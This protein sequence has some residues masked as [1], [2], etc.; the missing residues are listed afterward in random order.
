MSQP[1]RRLRPRSRTRSLLPLRFDAIRLDRRFQLD[2][3]DIQRFTDVVAASMAVSTRQ[4]FFTWTQGEAQG[5]VP[6]EI[7]LCG[8]RE[9]QGKGMAL[10]S[11]S[12]TRY[13]RDDHLRAVADPV[14]GLVPRLIATAERQQS[15]TVLC[16]IDDDA[17]DAHELDA[18]VRHNEMKNLAAGLVPGLNGQFD[19]VYMFGRIGATTGARVGT[20]LEMLVPHVHSA[21][22]RVLGFERHV[23]RT[24][25][26]AAPQ[27]VTRR[28]VEILNLVKSGKTNAEIAAVL[29]CSQ[30]T[31]KNHVQDILRRLGS[32]S[33]THAISRAISLGIL[34]AE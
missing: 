11:F 29:G 21:F 18:Q 22:V 12:A 14:E 1:T 30:W 7:L 34:S 8:V 6:H 25:S 2:D 9:P 16:G 26:E 5:L 32:S 23:G 28:Q 3:H 33:R 15:T 19:A 17:G 27:L 20:L 31:V 24:P 13:F 10:H 4:Q